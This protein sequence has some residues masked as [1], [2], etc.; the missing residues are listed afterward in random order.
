[1]S[2]A[3]KILSGLLLV[4]LFALQFGTQGLGQA[5]NFMTLITVLGVFA[6]AGIF[7][8][9][10]KYVAE[11]SEDPA[12]SATLFATS[13]RII[14]CFSALLAVIFVLFSASLSEWLFFRRDL[15]NVVIATALAQFGIAWSNYALAILKGRRDAKGNA[16]S[17]VVGTLLGVAAFIVGLYGFGYQ[18]ALI[19]LVL[20]PALTFLPAQLFLKKQG[21]RLCNFSAKFD[22]LQAL[23]L[24]KFS[25]MVLITAVTL[26]LGYILL[27]DLLMQRADLHAVGLWQGVAKISDAYLQF[28]TAAFSVY[29]LPTFAKLQEKAAIK[30]ELGKS[31]R[32]VALAVIVVSSAVYLL[33]EWIILLLYSAEFLA[34]EKL[35][36][37]QLLGDICK[38]LAYIFGY[39]IVAKG[40]LKLYALAEIFQVSVLLGSGSLLI[41]QFGAEGATMAY[42]A[43]YALYLTACLIGAKI[44]LKDEQKQ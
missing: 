19:G 27:R 35:F 2:T 31:L 30:R 3:V 6:G 34:M 32:I 37:W 12:K 25:A 20:M 4:K 1:M 41:P 5:A 21:V 29:L 28:I 38:V 7:N 9:I 26:P 42:F 8:G 11:F 22:R 36:F 23:S 33:R 24:S 17:I 14:L 16:L 13:N 39:L 43:T 18:G 15:Q 10:T 40:A 44:Y